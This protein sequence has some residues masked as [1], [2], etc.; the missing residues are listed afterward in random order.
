MPR[1]DLIPGLSTGL[2]GNGPHPARG[3]LFVQPRVRNGAEQ[4]LS[5]RLMDD[6]CGGGWRVVLGDAARAWPAPQF[7]PQSS[8][9]FTLLRIESAPRTGLSWVET[10][11]VLNAW[12]EQHGCAAAIVRPDHYVYAACTDLPTLQAEL[13]ALNVKPEPTHDTSA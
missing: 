8:P 10:E 13:N 12:F 3:R 11:G 6:A 2:L 4:G 1:Q 5:T 9:R 7:S